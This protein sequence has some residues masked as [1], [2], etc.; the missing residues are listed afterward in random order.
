[1][2]NFKF[3][4]FYFLLIL[5]SLCLVSFSILNIDSLDR[6]A[7]SGYFINPYQYTAFLTEEEKV[8]IF[9]SS[10]IILDPESLTNET[11]DSFIESNQQLIANLML[12]GISFMH[13]RSQ[14]ANGFE[15]KTYFDKNFIKY[16]LS[17][18]KLSN[19]C[20][21]YI[22]KTSLLTITDDI[23]NRVKR[24]T[25]VSGF[26][27]SADASISF[28]D[29]KNSILNL[30]EQ[31]LYEAAAN[32]IMTAVSKNYGNNYIFEIKGYFH[33]LEPPVYNFSASIIHVKIKGYIVFYAM[34]K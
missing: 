7:I 17:P 32:C 3:Y 34:Q 14:K 22:E 8:K 23:R 31:V 2:K 28:F 16:R 27:S 13:N 25:S 24:S 20:G 19:V 5:L 12:T 15:T 26:I 1:M 33:L 11:I 6:I 4:V 29:K 21:F 30:T 9:S 18:Y 10:N